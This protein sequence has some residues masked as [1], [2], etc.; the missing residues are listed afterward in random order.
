VVGTMISHLKTEPRNTEKVHLPQFVECLLMMRIEL[1]ECYA[2]QK[3][4]CSRVHGM[5]QKR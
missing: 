3:E 4:T 5:V 1:S 2:K